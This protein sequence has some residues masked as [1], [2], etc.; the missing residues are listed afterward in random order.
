MTAEWRPPRQASDS[1]LVAFSPLIPAIGFVLLAAVGRLYATDFD[2]YRRILT[3]WMLVPWD[4]AF[5]DLASIPAWVCCWHLHGL[6]V[7]TD[8]AWDLG[9]TLYSPLFLRLTF[10]PTDPA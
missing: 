4:H 7:Y 5:V 1:S 10:L 3:Y 9:P 6:A 2:L 8:A